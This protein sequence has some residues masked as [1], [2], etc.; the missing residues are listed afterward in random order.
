MT[1]FSSM[2]LQF[3]IFFGSVFFPFDS[4][5]NNFYCATRRSSVRELID[6]GRKKK[7]VQRPKTHREALFR[8]RM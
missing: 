4:R 5:W 7:S 8:K 6:S 3:E 2:Q 1:I